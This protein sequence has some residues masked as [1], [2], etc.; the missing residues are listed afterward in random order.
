[1]MD[2]QM[3]QQQQQQQQ[4]LDREMSHGPM[5][6]QMQEPLSRA[7]PAPAP[8]P[9][10]APIPT[11]VPA[12]V[13]AAAAAA[14]EEEASDASKCPDCGKVY[15]HAASL[16]KHRWEHSVYWKVRFIF[17]VNFCKCMMHFDESEHHV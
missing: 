10:A 15:K 16:L 13:A 4:Q 1:M 6:P 7:T 8:L 12:P 14:V 9:V 17:C 3:H 5:V 11:S 2:E